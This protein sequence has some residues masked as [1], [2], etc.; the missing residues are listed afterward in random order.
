MEILILMFVF[1]FGTIIGS[2]LNVVIYR[3][4]TSLRISKGRSICFSCN[5]QLYWYELLP[6]FS[7]MIQKGRCRGCASRISHQYPIVEI[8]TGI[9]FVFLS[10]HFL[11]MIFI[12]PLMYV[13]ALSFFMFIFALLIVIT[14][15][16]LRHKIIPDRLVYTFILLSL[17][18]IFLN[19]SGVGSLL[20]WPSLGQ[21]LAGPVIA[22]P[23]AL[24]WYFSKGVF[25][26]FGDIKLMLGL[27]W[28][29]GIS[30]GLSALMIAFWVGAIVG[31][32]MLAL[33]RTKVNMKTEVPFAPFLVLGIFVAFLLSLDIFT[34]ST[35]LIF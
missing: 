20:V 31:L 4:N 17:I 25:I 28:M 9:V 33:A 3:L 35:I 27:G 23:F 5:K 30:A 24:L 6:V 13:F 34:L 22:M 12:N 11:P 16:D 29:L 8:L 18:S 14:F 19:F 21:I 26:G 2:F 1:I 10:Y 32:F 15:Y 7:F